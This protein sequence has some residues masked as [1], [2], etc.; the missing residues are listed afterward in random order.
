VSLRV[1]VV[2]AGIGGL[3]L[4]QGLRRR[5][6]DVAVYERRASP[7]GWTSV[8]LSWVDAHG[9][10]ALSA[11][12]PSELYDLYQATRDRFGPSRR[13]FYD[14]HLNSL[15]ASVDDPPVR[16]CLVDRQVLRHVLLAGLDDAVSFGQVAS[17]YDLGAG[18]V[19]LRFADGAAV[20]GDV[21]VAADGINSMVRRALLPHFEVMDTGLRA[22]HGRAPLRDV[23]LND[24]PEAFL[25]DCPP[26]HGPRRCSLLLRPFQPY[27]PPQ[28]AAAEFAPYA[29]LPPVPGYLMWTLVLP[30][31][32]YPASGL[33]AAHEASLRIVALEA[34]EGW[35]PGIR[36]I[37]SASPPSSIFAAPV[38]AS[39][40]LSPWPVT[41][42][43][44]L[45][46][47]VYVA[48]SFGEPCVDLGLGGAAL[49]AGL[50]SDV[51]EPAT[52]LLPAIDR[53]DRWLRYCS[54]QAVSR[55]MLDVI[56]WEAR[57]ASLRPN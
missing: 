7:E 50:L 1:L 29:R 22:I 49:L 30:A 44:A 38:R 28:R 9:D 10:A 12:L 27:V 17:G 24:L 13:V 37:L 47:A 39:T 56:E 52:E 2:G 33:T 25:R 42:V 57:H 14:H 11:C 20:S 53:Y 54:S 31:E 51:R 36:R 35:H 6:V 23:W 48:P 21:L 4:A 41:A 8:G 16:G 43:T 46:D 55:S 18:G 32:S 45:A 15:T 3:C 34:T 5:G 26:M 19:R 40:P